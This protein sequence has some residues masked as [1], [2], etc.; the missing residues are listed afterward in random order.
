MRFKKRNRQPDLV[1]WPDLIKSIK[2]KGRA[3]GSRT[4]TIQCPICLNT[5][6]CDA[7]YKNWDKLAGCTGDMY[8]FKYDNPRR[9]FDVGPKVGYGK[10]HRKTKM[11]ARTNLHLEF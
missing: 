3:Q 5:H 9:G 11:R 6:V 4:T 10:P 8:L 1:L 7:E 2:Q